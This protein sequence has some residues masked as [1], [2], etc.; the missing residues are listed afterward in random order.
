MIFFNQLIKRNKK[1]EI[2]YITCIGIAFIMN[3]CMHD[4][5]FSGPIFL[6]KKV[7]SMNIAI[8]QYVE[9]F[10]FLEWGTITCLSKVSNV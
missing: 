2:L 9:P 5:L 1:H 6:K 7:D 4:I 8:Y 10:L 3:C